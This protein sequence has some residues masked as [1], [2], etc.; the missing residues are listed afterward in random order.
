MNRATYIF[1]VFSDLKLKHVGIINW[2]S[3]FVS[4]GEISPSHPLML[5]SFPWS[6]NVLPDNFFYIIHSCTKFPNERFSLQ[7]RQ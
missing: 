7:T 1:E 6:D 3:N 2:N 5:H 4:E